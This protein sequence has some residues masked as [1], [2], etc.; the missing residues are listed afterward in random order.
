MRRFVAVGLILLS[1]GCG[2]GKIATKGIVL[3]DGAPFKIKDDEFVRI[4]FV[5]MP[6]NGGKAMDFYIATFNP[7]DSTFE[8]KGKDLLGIPPGK[9]RVSV[10]H[11]K[12]RKD[13][14]N[15]AFDA[16]NS[17]F[18]VTIQSAADEVKVDVGK[19]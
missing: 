6:E 19:K 7:A 18:V 9:Y 8:A 14:F 2:S 11:M 5:P 10:E 12:G 16:V 3:K 4:M 13:A 1:A 15:G 17:P